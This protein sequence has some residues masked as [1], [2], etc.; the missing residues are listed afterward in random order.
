M[1]QIIVWISCLVL[2]GY[3]YQ[4]FSTHNTLLG[5]TTDGIPAYQPYPLGSQEIN[6]VNWK[7]KSVITGL[8]WECVEFVR[9]YLLLTRGIIFK[10]VKQANQIWGLLTFIDAERNTNIPCMHYGI[11]TIQP[12]HGDVLVW[13]ISE[14]NPDGHV[15]IIV[16]DTDNHIGKVQIAEQNMGS[17]K[18]PHYSRHIDL[19]KTPDLLGIIRIP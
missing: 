7:G 18:A 8:R 10:D 3:V 17:W 11:G 16:S 9:R 13:A 5:T 15:A 1:K 6:H 2:I 12:R 14:E 4:Y 19:E